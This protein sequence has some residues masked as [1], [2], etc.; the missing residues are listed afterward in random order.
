MSNVF[1]ITG[2]Q[3]I[4]PA[5][6]RCGVSGVMRRHVL[7]LLDAAGIACGVRDVEVDELWAADGVFISNSQIGILPA[8][9]CGS[10]SW[11]PQPLI[12]R[13]TDMLRHSGIYEGPA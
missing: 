10:H 6:T 9:R 13:L 11:L 7:T 3:L 2:Q 5:I 1:L 12:R 8:K 4:T